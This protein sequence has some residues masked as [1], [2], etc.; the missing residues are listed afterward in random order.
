MAYRWPPSYRA[1]T[2]FHAC[3]R[4][5]LKL[6]TPALTVE[7]RSHHADKVCHSSAVKTAMEGYHRASSL[8]DAAKDTM[9]TCAARSTM[10]TSRK[11]P[12]IHVLLAAVSSAL[13][14]QSQ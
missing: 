6:L 3:A 7:Y 9:A 1:R 2:S 10:A 13:S 4:V 5:L 12:L 8:K 14:R 11:L